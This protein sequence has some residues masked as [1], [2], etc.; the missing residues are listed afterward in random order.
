MKLSGLHLLLTYQCTFECD[1]C[2]VWGSPR[3]SGVMSLATIRLILEQA[4]QMETVRTICFEGGEPFLYYATLLQG[5]HEA[6]ARGFQVGI[7]TNTFWATSEEDALAALKPMAGLVQSLTLSSDL[8]HFNEYLSRQAQNAQLAAS[9][10]GISTSLISIAKPEVVDALAGTGQIPAGESG[11]MYRGRAALKLA[12]RVHQ[13][14]WELFDRCPHENLANPGRVHL[15]P[16]G[17]VHICQGISIGNFLQTPL[18]EIAE[19]YEPTTHPITAPLLA[20]GP[21]GLARAYQLSPCETYADACHLCYGM[22]CSLRGQF[23][24]ILAPQSMYFA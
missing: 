11:V 10:L 1:H 23:P 12:G 14:P 2:F 3:Q 9:Q 20:G 6:A 13:Q 18:R 22:R 16:F 24:E 17:F 15:D 21:A 8:F 7:V 4:S 5:V 19:R